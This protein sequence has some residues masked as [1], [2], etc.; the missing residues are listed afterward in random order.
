VLM[1][2][3]LVKDNLAQF[4]SS[5]AQPDRIKQRTT[6]ATTVRGLKRGAFYRMRLGV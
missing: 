3:D 1:C 2:L 6:K 5:P 4:G